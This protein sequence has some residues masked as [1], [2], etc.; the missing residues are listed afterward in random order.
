[1]LHRL[2]QTAPLV[3]ALR[4][5]RRTL[6]GFGGNAAAKPEEPSPYEQVSVAE[7]E[8][9]LYRGVRAI[10]YDDADAIVMRDC[11]MWAQL[12]DN[13]QGIIKLTSGGLAK[14]GDGVPTTEIDSPTGARINGK[15]AM[16]MVVVDKL[17][18]IHI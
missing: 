12:R 6:L 1:M 9:L 14:S 18:L 8:D 17:S 13:N 15:Q 7:A 3:S 11:M 5:Q 16:S 2:R 10:G 4:G